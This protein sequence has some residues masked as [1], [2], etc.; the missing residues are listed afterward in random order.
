MYNIV[1]HARS[2]SRHCDDKLLKAFHQKRFLNAALVQ[3]S[4]IWLL[5]EETHAHTHTLETLHTS[6][7][8]RHQPTPMIKMAP[9][10]ELE[11]IVVLWHPK[12]YPRHHYDIC[13][14]GSYRIPKVLGL[15]ANTLSC[16]PC[17]RG[18]TLDCQKHSSAC[19]GCCLMGVMQH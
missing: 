14:F 9:Q 11:C 8:F 3:I 4:P 17:S 16:T 15:V 13:S 2:C 12:S 18:C 19:Q 10:S 1:S 7:C 5:P 6:I